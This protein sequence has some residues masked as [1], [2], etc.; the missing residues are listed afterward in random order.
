MTAVEW[1]AA[2]DCE[3]KNIIVNGSAQGYQDSEQRLVGFVDVGYQ[4]DQQK[5]GEFLQK[6]GINTD[7]F[8]KGK[9]KS[10][11]VLTKELL[12]GESSFMLDQTT[13]EIVRYVEIVWTKI[14][15]STG[16]FLVEMN[17]QYPDGKKRVVERMPGGKRRPLESVASA[18]RRI[19][20]KELTLPDEM[21]KLD[22]ASVGMEIDTDL[23]TEDIRESPSYPGLKSYYRIYIVPAEIDTSQADE[24]LLAEFGLPSE[25]PFSTH[26]VTGDKHM[27]EWVEEERAKEIGAL[28]LDKPK[29]EQGP[30]KFEG[31]VSALDNLWED[32]A[33][34]K[35]LMNEY[36]IDASSG[37]E[38]IQK[39]LEAGNVVILENSSINKIVI[40]KDVISIRAKKD[41]DVLIDSS[42]NTLPSTVRGKDSVKKGAQRLL[43][44]LNDNNVQDLPTNLKIA[45]ELVL[46]EEPHPSVSGIQVIV[47]QHIVDCYLDGD[48][49]EN[50]E[51][52]AMDHCT[53]I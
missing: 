26:E 20:A 10:L 46:R 42:C 43:K 4:W 44:E 16:K 34:L 28:S 23:V 5:V 40:V 37:V 24:G 51:E 47:R 13:Q 31:L 36:Q 19:L 33:T 22:V 45:N 39:D 17:R 35:E 12:R 32:S 53:C 41:S 1:R 29:S 27:W 2:L 14:R 38:L 48:D 9:A 7:A 11:P 49:M 6:H 25:E 15:R 21:I 30:S 8:G 18:A 52:S 50:A 3:A